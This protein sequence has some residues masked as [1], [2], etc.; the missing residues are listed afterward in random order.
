[1]P[2][3]AIEWPDDELRVYATL[4][5]P[6]FAFSD[7]ALFAYRQTL[8]ADGELQIRGCIRCTPSTEASSSRL[9]KKSP[10]RLLCWGASMW[11]VT[12]A[13]SRKRY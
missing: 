5:G 8:S 1:M 4:R 7:D 9:R 3:Y 2:S 13:L 11:G 6:F 10:T 12:A